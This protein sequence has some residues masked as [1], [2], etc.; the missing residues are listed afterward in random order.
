MGINLKARVNYSTKIMNNK[1]LGLILMGPAS[2]GKSS[3][4]GSLGVRTLYLYGSGESHGPASAKHFNP[5]CDLIPVCFD[6][7][8][9]GN[10]VD[11]DQAYQD[12]V[13]LLNDRKQI[14]EAGVK[15]IVLDGLTELEHLILSTTTYKL[16]LASEYKGQKSFAGPIVIDMARSV[17]NAIRKLQTELDIHY[18]I[19]CLLIVKEVAENGVFTDASPQVNGFNVANAILQQIPDR[20]VIGHV[21]MGDG[22]VQPRLQVG[23]AVGRVTKDFSTKAITKIASFRCQLT[24]VDLSNAST[25]APNLANVIEYKKAGRLLKKEELAAIKELNQAIPVG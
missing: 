16:R 17:L 22:K 9:N 15:A 11:P 4:M 14:E 10:Q 13:D 1:N 21:E 5:G 19:S 2:A 23:A 18:V 7:D 6:L 12:L 3:A 25:L 24:G 8:E 20:L